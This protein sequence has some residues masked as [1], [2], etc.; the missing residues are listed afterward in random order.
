MVGKDLLCCWYNYYHDWCGVALDIYYKGGSPCGEHCVQSILGGSYHVVCWSLYYHDQYAKKR[1]RGQALIST[2]Y[3]LFRLSPCEIGKASMGINPSVLFRA[4]PELV[5][6]T[7]S[8]NKGQPIND[9][10][11]SGNRLL[12]P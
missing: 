1:K 10:N 5:E 2:I 11:N 4:C 12:F 9:C 8:K 3:Y 6:G 7:A